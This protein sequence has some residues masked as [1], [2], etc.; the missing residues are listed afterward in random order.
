M[1]FALT[2]LMALH[3][4]AHLVGFAGAWQLAPAKELPYKTTV[5]AGRVQLG[6]AGIRVMGVLW[7]VAALAFVATAGGAAL[8][9]TWWGRAALVVALASLALTIV[10]WPEA[11]IGLFVNLA[12]LGALVIVR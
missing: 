9:A 8:N 5:L 6:D 4:V 7:L 3:G 12:I 11:R 10:E 2:A 1:R